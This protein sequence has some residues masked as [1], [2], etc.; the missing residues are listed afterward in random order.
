MRWLFVLLIWVIASSDI[1]GKDMSLGPGLSPKNAVLYMI[2]LAMFFRVALS[3][4]GLRMKLP[5]LQ[6]AFAVWIVYATL[7]FVTCCVIVHYAAY[8]IVV[9]GILLKAQLF[10]AALFCFTVFYALQDE[11]DFKSLIKTLVAAIG[12]SSVLTLTDVAGLTHLGSKVGTEGGEADRVFGMFGHANETGAMLVCILPVMLAVAVNS[13][14]AARL[15]WYG[16]A[17]FTLAVL[18]LTVSRGAYVGFIL[19]YGAACFICRRYIPVSK[20]ASWLVGGLA[21]AL[22][23]CVLVSVVEPRVGDVVLSRLTGQS[24][25]VDMSEVS[26]GRTNIW[27]NT[28]SH[29]MGDPWTF[30]TGYGWNVYDTRFVFATHNYYLDLLFNLGIIGLSAFL[31][32]LYQAAASARRA[33]DDASPEMRPYM[34]ALVFGVLGLGVSIM[35]TNLSK[36]WPY[37]WLYFGMTLSMAGAI[38]ARSERKEAAE[39]PLAGP[40]IKVA[41]G[42]QSP[43]PV[44]RRRGPLAPAGR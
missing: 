41:R 2:A 6:A 30:I 29:M 19:G 14:G 7:S 5:M 10:D 11:A 17:F 44:P 15:A 28:I 9:S 4:N 27:A 13:R 40:A 21:A 12:V 18:I 3:G 34:I 8:N 39:I 36:P 1:L 26:S 24:S 33:M 42:G 31:A 23:L 38:L 20:V 37:I 16:G 43:A 35:F 32:I 25:A 22:V